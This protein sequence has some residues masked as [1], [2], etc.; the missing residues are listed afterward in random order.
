MYASV[1]NACSAIVSMGRRTPAMRASTLDHP[2]TALTTRPAA[3]VPRFV[4][5][6]RHS[7]S[8]TSTSITSTP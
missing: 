1:T 6:P 2:A 7:P 5:T 4:T 3:T 8:T